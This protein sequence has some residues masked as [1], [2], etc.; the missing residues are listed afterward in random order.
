MDKF[1]AAFE[2]LYFMSASD[3]EI[4]ESE[5]HVILDFLKANAGKYDFDPERVIQSI[6][7]LNTE[8]MLEEL[9]RA[10]IIF[11]NDSSAQDRITLL[12]FALDLISV[13]GEISAGERDL[14]CDLANLWNIDVHRYLESRKG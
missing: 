11:K 3:G 2:V 1:Q 5:L 13:D 4:G 10:A 6:S 7:A 14:F 9:E 8:G 12:D